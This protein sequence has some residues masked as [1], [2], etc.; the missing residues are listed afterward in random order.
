MA[1]LHGNFTSDNRRFFSRSVAALTAKGKLAVTIGS[2]HRSHPLDA[3]VQDRFYTIIDSNV[4][5]VPAST[6]SAITDSNLQDISGFSSGYND[7]SKTGWRSDLATGEKVFNEANVLRGEVFFSIYIPPVTVCSND[8]NGSR[9]IVI[10]L[11]GNATRDIDSNI[12]NGKEFYLTVNNF[13]ILPKMALHYGSTG[14]VHGIFLPDI[15]NVYT[16]GSLE[17]KIWANNP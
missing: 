7:T 6:P 13:G 1:D 15:G 11:E 5:A 8:P 9:L 10:D 3:A 4:S 16:S 12:S 17:D 2:G 14:K